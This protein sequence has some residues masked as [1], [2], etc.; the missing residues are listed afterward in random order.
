MYQHG[1]KQTLK[2]GALVFGA[3]AIFLAIAPGKFLELLDFESTPELI[4]S[5]RMIAIT[6]FA[7]AGNMW[8]NSKINNNAG[9]LRFVALVMTV[10]AASLGLLTILIPST[11]TPVVI[12]YTVIGF[13]FAI[14]YLINIFK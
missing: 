13:T 4:W 6:L 12:I 3:S 2:S 11:L 1:V 14:T 5:M 10:A 7:L 9:G 8:Q